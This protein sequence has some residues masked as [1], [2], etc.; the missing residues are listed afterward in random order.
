MSGTKFLYIATLILFIFTCV[1]LVF[2]K[3]SHA[4][5]RT[6]WVS[7]VYFQETVDASPYFDN[8][9]N[10]DLKVRGALTRKAYK[11]MYLQGFMNFST[12]QRKIIEN[13]LTIANNKLHKNFARLYSIPWKL[14]K[15]DASLENGFPHTL[16]DVI[17]LSDAFFSRPIGDM[18]ATLIH[19][20][21]H[22]FQRLYPKETLEIV[23]SMGFQTYDI[24][25][26]TLRY[27]S[28]PDLPHTC[29]GTHDGPIVQL[30]ND[31]PVTLFDSR[32]ILITPTKE[33]TITSHDLGL[34][35]YVHQVEHP[36]EIMASIIPELALQR[37]DTSSHIEKIIANMMSI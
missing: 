2:R 15:I 25:K 8:M 1:Y 29:Y 18:T 23:K 26:K 30:Y 16:G 33:I 5:P 36:Y 27:R 21:V 20:K 7:K 9:N 12:N 22:V 19:E 11:N 10:F 34:P 3:L 14:A 4:R 31:N 13:C 6:E 28:N 17:I 24:D 37:R 32:P 35:S